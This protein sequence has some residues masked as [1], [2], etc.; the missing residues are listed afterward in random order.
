MMDVFLYMDISSITLFV[1]AEAI[2]K[3]SGAIGS[4]NGHHA[5]VLRVAEQYVEAFG[6]IAKTGTTS[7]FNSRLKDP[8]TFS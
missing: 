6:N 7:N 4:S 5:V 3:I 1:K 2:T 8:F